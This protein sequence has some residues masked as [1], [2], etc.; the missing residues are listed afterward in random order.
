VPA[1]GIDNRLSELLSM[2]RGHELGVIPMLQF[3]KQVADADSGL[4]EELLNDCHS[5]LAGGISNA[6]ELATQLATGSLTPTM[7]K[8]RLNE[9]RSDRWLLKPASLR[10]TGTTATTMLAEAGLPPGHPEATGDRAF[11]PAQEAAYTEAKTTTRERTAEEYGRAPDPYNFNSLA[12]EEQ[13]SERLRPETQAALEETNY[14]TTLPLVRELP[15]ETSY[16]ASDDRVTCEACGTEYPA[17]FDGLMDALH[18]HTDLSTIT[19]EEIPPVTLGL[20]LDEDVI[21]AADLSRRQL[22][23]LQVLYNA[24]VDTYDPRELALVHDRLQGVLESLGIT[25]ADLEALEDAGYLT[26]ESLQQYGYWTVTKAGRDRLDE[27][28][29]RD[30][31]W[32]PTNGDLNETLLHRVLVEALAQYLRQEHAESSESAVQRVERYFEP[33]AEGID[34]EG[35]DGGVRFDVVGLSGD[36]EIVAIGE[37]ELANNDRAVAAVHDYD[38]IAAV[39]PDHAIWAVESSSEGQRAVIQPL[40]DPPEDHGDLDDATPRIHS[41]SES[42]RIS[43]ISGVD[44][45]GMTDIMTLTRLRKTIAEP[46]VE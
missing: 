22:C 36:G 15:G 12:N 25:D 6:D 42:T 23:A 38:R 28:H 21:Q 26:P 29:R 40:G 45:S 17:S 39:D 35:L 4:Y 31:R 37:A 14:R 16:D 13:L 19:R 44:T 7:A 2:G 1:L 41:Y 5:I 20:T 30:V 27:P 8:R 3:P 43:D 9:L 18:C 10:G 34:I 24:A 33:A 46:T 11:S 32:G